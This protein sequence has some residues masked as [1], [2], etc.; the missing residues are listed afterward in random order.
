MAA[1]RRTGRGVAALSAGVAL[2]TAGAAAGQTPNPWWSGYDKG[3]QAVPLG[4]GRTINL[5]CEGQGAPVV[6]LDAGL[7]D[8]AASW[9]RVQDQIAA[10]TRVCSYDRAGYG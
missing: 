5:Y 3:S 9:R 1:K 10:R 7:G 2:S 6:V 4:G 8:G